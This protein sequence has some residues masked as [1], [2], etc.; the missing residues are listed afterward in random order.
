MGTAHGGARGGDIAVSGPCVRCAALAKI[1]ESVESKLV[2]AQLRYVDEVIADT[3]RIK[4]AEIRGF[5]RGY[6]AAMESV[7]KEMGGVFEV[8]DGVLKRRGE[9]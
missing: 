7:F 6:R 2:E 8:V 1:V 4:Q 5:D 3:E 9:G